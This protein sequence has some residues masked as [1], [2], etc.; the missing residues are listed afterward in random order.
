MRI[1]GIGLTRTGTTSLATAIAKLGFSVIHY[2]RTEP[3]LAGAYM[4]AFDLPVVI[5]YKTLDAQFSGSK[6]IYTV[7]DKGAWLDSMEAYLNA[8]QVASQGQRRNRK[9]VYGQCDFD[10]DIYSAA[11]D[12]HH[13]DVMLYFKDRPD[14][15]L[16]I[17]ICGGDGWAPLL[18]FLN[19]DA[20]VADFP[21]KHK[22][23]VT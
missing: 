21:N 11:Y 20:D 7:R 10:R 22:R 23:G 16:V 6:F 1:F 13:N 8:R 3:L 4:A 12:R 5:H 14:D 9:K 19:I 17:D 18:S 15:L 2:P